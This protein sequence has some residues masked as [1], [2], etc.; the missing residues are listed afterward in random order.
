M[1]PEIMT[2]KDML[3]MLSTASGTHSL[4]TELSKSGELE[5][6]MMVSAFLQSLYIVYSWKLECL[7]G[8]LIELIRAGKHS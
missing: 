4:R 7:P 8:N 6:H 5:V 3:G 1:V 2:F